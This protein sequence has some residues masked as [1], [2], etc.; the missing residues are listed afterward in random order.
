MERQDSKKTGDHRIIRKT[1]SEWKALPWNLGEEAQL[2]AEAL[3][4]L[5]QI[6]LNA[7]H[8]EIRRSTLMKRFS[9]GKDKYQRVINELKEARYL[10]VG[11]DRDE[12]GKITGSHYLAFDQPFQANEPDSGKP[13]SR[14]NRNPAQPEAGSTGSRETRQHN[15]EESLTEKKKETEREPGF[16]PGGVSRVENGGE[17]LPPDPKRKPA[18]EHRQE[19]RGFQKVQEAKERAANEK[20]MAQ[21]KREQEAEEQR[22]RDRKLLEQRIEQLQ[23]ESE[24]EESVN[25]QEPYQSAMEIFHTKTYPTPKQWEVY[26]MQEMKTYPRTEAEFNLERKKFCVWWAEKLLEQNGDSE[27]DLL[28]FAIKVSS[29]RVWNKFRTS[30]LSKPHK[31]AVKQGSNN[32]A[33]AAAYRKFD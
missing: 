6:L 21:L 14:E 7:D 9:M 13:G 31:E 3:G 8:Y 11:Y 32:R 1:R 10:S 33:A 27:Q 12:S 4:M 25:W 28:R 20:K 16:P 19:G 24:Q 30:F 2:S 17:F 23:K 22:Q 5:T 29:S 26:A 15:R 18:A